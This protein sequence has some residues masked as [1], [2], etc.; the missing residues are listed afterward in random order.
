MNCVYVSESLEY[1]YGIRIKARGLTDFF[2]CKLLISEEHGHLEC[3][4]IC[5]V[6]VIWERT[7][8]EKEEKIF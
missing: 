5:N 2:Y 8:E 1:L 6:F 7:K 3:R 4:N